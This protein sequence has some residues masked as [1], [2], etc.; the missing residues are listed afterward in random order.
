M[1]EPVMF[2]ESEVIAGVKA[3]ALATISLFGAVYTGI[4]AVVGADGSNTIAIG[5]TLGVSVTFAGL[6]LRMVIKDQGAIWD[7]VRSKDEEIVKKNG[8]IRQLKLEKE[9]AQWQTEQARFRANERTDPGP[10]QPSP[11]LMAP[12]PEMGTTNSAVS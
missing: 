10:F 4:T 12:S 8:E 7:I 9:Y 1:S 2:V 5:T 11:G 6:I 3:M